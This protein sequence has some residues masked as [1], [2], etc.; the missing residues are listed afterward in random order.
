MIVLDT[1]VWLWWQTADEKLSSDAR[2]AIDDAALIGVCTISCYEIARANARGRIALDREVRTWVAQALAAE[3]VTPIE[4]TPRV[5]TAAG[6]LGPEFPGDP[7]DRII[8]ATTVD[9][10]G[11]LVTRDRALRR[12]DPARTIW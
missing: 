3:R 7:V 4:L 1:H 5:A 12:L 2:A 6:T 9:C 11:Q 10:Q 8:Y